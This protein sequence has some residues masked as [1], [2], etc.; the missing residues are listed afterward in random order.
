LAS[1]SEQA[2][3]LANVATGQLGTDFSREDTPFVVGE[4]EPKGGTVFLVAAFDEI[5]P[6]TVAG[7]L[8]VNPP[9]GPV[10]TYV[11]SE[12]DLKRWDESLRCV[13]N[14]ELVLADVF[15]LTPGSNERTAAGR[16]TLWVDRSQHFDSHKCK[17]LMTYEFSGVDRLAS[18][19][20]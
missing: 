17:R 19:K 7:S 16:R 8:A 4:R 20:A 5:Q 1:G 18:I 11:L 14:Q 12:L 10:Q 9:D 6:I 3:P 13:A 15:L 2:G